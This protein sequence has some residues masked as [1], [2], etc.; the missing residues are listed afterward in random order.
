MVEDRYQ[1]IQKYVQL[2]EDKLNKAQQEVIN[3]QKEMVA[4]KAS[5][6]YI[7][8]YKCNCPPNTT[9]TMAHCPNRQIDNTEF[10]TTETGY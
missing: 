1:Y 7:S 10:N 4:L 3:L 5:N 2:L 8:G 9:C 6:N